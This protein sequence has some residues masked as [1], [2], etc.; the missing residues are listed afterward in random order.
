MRICSKPNC[1]SGGLRAP[2]WKATTLGRVRAEL[3]G[4]GEPLREQE[5]SRLPSQLCV[6]H[7]RPWPSDSEFLAIY[8]PVT[9]PGGRSPAAHI[10]QKLA[11]S[12]VLIRCQ[13]NNFPGHSFNKTRLPN[14]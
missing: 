10:L 2:G 11:M 6:S 1:R 13:E 7:L 14:D 9:E 4:G 12:Q 8:R 3:G 5:A